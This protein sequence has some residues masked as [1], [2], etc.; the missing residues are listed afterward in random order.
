MIKDDYF[1]LVPDYEDLSATEHPLVEEEVK[2]EPVSSTVSSWSEEMELNWSTLL[3]RDDLTGLRNFFKQGMDINIV[4]EKVRAVFVSFK[5]SG[6]VGI[7]KPILNSGY[8]RGR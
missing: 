6:G 8:G 1:L 3:L 4:E 2:L 5:N 7:V